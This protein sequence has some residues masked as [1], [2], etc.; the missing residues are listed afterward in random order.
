[1]CLFSS[2]ALSFSAITVCMCYVLRLTH[3][4]V[5]Y[6]QSLISRLDSQ[7]KIFYF[8]L[9]LFTSL[10]YFYSSCNKLCCSS[11]WQKQW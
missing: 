6:L 2:F 11:M 7:K 3:N 5:Y 10:I 1:M 8:T 4:K 9:C